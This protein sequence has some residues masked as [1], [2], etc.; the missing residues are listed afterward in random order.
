MP[1]EKEFKWGFN[2]HVNFYPTPEKFLE[3]I[4]VE[5]KQNNISSELFCELGDLMYVEIVI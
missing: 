2:Y 4:G 1:L 3:L 5:L